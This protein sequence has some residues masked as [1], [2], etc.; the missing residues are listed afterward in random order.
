LRGGLCGVALAIAWWPGIA[1]AC[2][3][4][5]GRN[6][7]PASLLL[8]A[9]IIALPFGLTLA[10]WPIVRRAQAAQPFPASPDPGNPERVP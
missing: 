9:G 8:L 4:C 3:Y 10:I 5:A 6:E 1:Q 2:P 7:D